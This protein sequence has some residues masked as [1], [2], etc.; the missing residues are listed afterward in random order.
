MKVEGAVT[1]CLNKK[2]HKR[3]LP[4]PP[5]HVL[6]FHTSASKIDSGRTR[7]RRRTINPEVFEDMT[8]YYDS[9]RRVGG[10]AVYFITIKCLHIS[11]TTLI[12]IRSS[13]TNWKKR[14]PIICLYTFIF[15]NTWT[16]KTSPLYPHVHC[17]E[18]TCMWYNF[19]MIKS[20]H[21]IP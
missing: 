21:H 11:M 5:L 4:P 8:N 7:M 1:H 17:H 6:Q 19:L 15:T 12:I 9:L 13:Y 18:K 10:G 20:K 3:I 16:F 2:K 14:L